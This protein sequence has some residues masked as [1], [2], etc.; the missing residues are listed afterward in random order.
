MLIARDYKK[1]II[2]SAIDKALKIPR[3][4]AIKK[5][6]RET[7]K[8]RVVFSIKYD[9]RLPSL[10]KIVQKHHRTMV[11]EDPRL[12]EIFKQPPMIAYKRHRNLKDMLIRSK[13]PKV[14]NSRPKRNLKGMKK[15]G[16]CV[17]CPYIKEGRKIKST[18]TNY[19]KEINQKVDCNSEN[20]IYLIECNKSNCR[21][22]YVGCSDQPFKLRMSQH[23]GYA[24]NK[25]IEKATGYHFSQK[26]QSVADMKFSIIE[27]IH[28]KNRF[29]LLETEKHYIRKFN[30]KYK[31]MNK[32]C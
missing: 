32:N 27:K 30:T 20:T 9:P 23:R 25:K 29:Y 22:Q 31:G 1:N 13:V 7:N 19:S 26:N 14:S 15:C 21:Q 28:I 8:D 24:N 5:V 16:I 12:K 3:K 18:A 11:E 6:F 10:S 17:I 4:E 2:N